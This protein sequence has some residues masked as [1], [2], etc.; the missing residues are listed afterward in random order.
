[1]FE[2][3]SCSITKFE[4]ARFDCRNIPV[5]GLCIA[6]RYC[7][8][9]RVL[10]DILVP[11]QQQYQAFDTD[12]E[13]SLDNNAFTSDVLSSVVPGS[14]ETANLDAFGANLVDHEDREFHGNNC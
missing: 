5:P 7:T 12:D 6:F 11:G 8:F 3:A 2:I 14:G 4:I 1:M 9:H 10:N 13:F